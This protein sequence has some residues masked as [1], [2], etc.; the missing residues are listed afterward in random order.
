MT[1][2]TKRIPLTRD[3]LIMEIKII[4]DAKISNFE[5]GMEF[6]WWAQ[7]RARFAV[8]RSSDD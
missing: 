4:A 8:E 3:Q 7:N 5:D 6:M 1:D 2:T